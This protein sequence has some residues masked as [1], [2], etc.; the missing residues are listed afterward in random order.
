MEKAEA[1]IQ[2]KLGLPGENKPI[3]SAD[4]KVVEDIMAE[5]RSVNEEVV[6]NDDTWTVSNTKEEAKDA[7]VYSNKLLDV[8]G[9]QLKPP[10]KS[11]KHTGASPQ[12]SAG[13]SPSNTWSPSP[14]AGS[15][16]SAATNP[17]VKWN[18]IVVL[19]AFGRA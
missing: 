7:T 10:E 4:R 6:G 12:H 8:G 17:G 16:P 19:H 9:I 1:I 13:P 18:H 11:P 2:D 15:T 3:S 5:T 14:K